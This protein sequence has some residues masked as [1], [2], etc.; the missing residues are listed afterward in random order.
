MSEEEAEKKI[1]EDIKEFFGIRNIEESEDYFSKLPSEYRH[2]LVDKMVTKAIES[3]E[4][5]AQLVADTFRRAVEKN[6]C[7][8]ESFQEGFIPTAEILDDIAI[9]A[10]KAFGLMAI[11][12]IGAGLDKDEERYS[13]IADKLEDKDQLLSH[14]T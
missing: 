12:M 1:V 2:R 10:P 3:K 14:F 11:M 13:R 7:S 8:P 4:T 9:D 6:L 5:D